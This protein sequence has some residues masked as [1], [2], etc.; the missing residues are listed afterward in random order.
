VVLSG[1]LG[2]EVHRRY[3]KVILSGFACVFSVAGGDCGSLTSKPTLSLSRRSS[4]W[5]THSVLGLS[6]LTAH[7]HTHTLTLSLLNSHRVTVRLD[8]PALASHNSL[9]LSLSCVYR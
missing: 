9:S 8:V 3:C 7:T 2:C 4:R 5:D 6:S 1:F